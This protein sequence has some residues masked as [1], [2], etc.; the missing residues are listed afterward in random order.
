MTI[1]PYNFLKNSNFVLGKLHTV[2]NY[3]NRNSTFSYSNNKFHFTYPLYNNTSNPF[4]T[5]SSRTAQGPSYHRFLYGQTSSNNEAIFKQR[6]A[7]ALETYYDVKLPLESFYKLIKRINHIPSKV[8]FEYIDFDDVYSD[9]DRWSK[10]GISDSCLNRL[11]P[12]Y[13]DLWEDVQKPSKNP[14]KY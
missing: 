8:V 13:K 9:Y 1:P 3:V 5:F 7:R 4:V 2:I 11:L 14:W 12:Y 6:V 10:Y